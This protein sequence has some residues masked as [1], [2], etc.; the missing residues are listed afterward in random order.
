MELAN[1][2]T[3]LRVRGIRTTYNEAT[4]STQR[5]MITLSI[6]RHSNICPS[7]FDGM[8]KLLDKNLLLSGGESEAT[9]STHTSVEGRETSEEAT[10]KEDG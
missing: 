3:H 7:V 2:N 6:E 9:A 10:V 5:M 4:K 1:T 8:A